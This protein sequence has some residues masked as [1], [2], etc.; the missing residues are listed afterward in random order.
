MKKTYYWVV[1]AILLLTLAVSGTL[2]AAADGNTRGGKCGTNASWVFHSDTGELIISGQGDMEDYSSSRPPPWISC[3]SSITSVKIGEGITSIANYA[4]LYCNNLASVSLPNSLTSVGDYAFYGCSSLIQIPIPKTVTHLGNNAFMGCV[5]LKV[6]IL[7]HGI[8]S[9]PTSLFSGC[10]QLMAVNVPSTVTDIG[11]EAFRDCAA[12]PS[13]VLPNGITTVGNAAF[14]G[15]ESLSEIRFPA[16]VTSIGDSALAFCT[17][18]KTVHLPNTLTDLGKNILNGSSPRLVLFEGQKEEWQTVRIGEENSILSRVLLIHP[19]HLFNREVVDPLYHSSDADCEHAATC[20]RSCACGAAGEEI[21]SYGEPLGHTGGTATCLRQ[22]VCDTCQKPYGLLIAHS[23]DGV[24]DC[25]RGVYCAVCETMLEPAKG[26][27]HH[28]VVV[29]PTCTEEGYTTHTCAD[30][31]DTY[32][33]T[34]IE[35]TGHTPGDAPTCLE[36]QFCTV[37]AAKLA[38]RLGHSYVGVVTRTPTCT[39]QGVRT[40]SCSRCADG[41]A[42]SIEPT[43]HTEGTAP[44]C[45]TP[46]LCTVCQTVLAD[47]LGHNYR[48]ETVAPTC[49]TR[50]HTAHTCDRCATTY[51]DEFIPAKGH[52]PGNAATCTTAQTCTVCQTVLADS[53]GHDYRAETVAP[54]CDEQGYIRH[55]CARCSAAY[56]DE[57]VPAKGH[58]PGD[59][60]TCTTAQTCTVCQTVLADSPGHDYRAETV[61]PTCVGQGYVRHSCARCSAAYLDELVPAKGHVPGDAPTC[62]APQTCTVCHALLAEPAEHTYEESVTEATCTVDGRVVHTCSLCGDV[63][64]DSIIPATGHTAGDWTVDNEPDIGEPGRQHKSC[65]VCSA[66]LEAETFWDSHG[67]GTAP[68]PDETDAANDLPPEPNEKKDRAGC[69]ITAG[70]VIVIVIILIAAFVLWYLDR[71]RK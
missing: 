40:H 60:P 26:H 9:I 55:S 24:A 8:T 37:C 32:T 71:R 51:L 52:T 44:T 68:T 33:D 27:R 42:E 61:D 21:F 66:I 20:Y 43:G 46:Q 25:V 1:A 4:F 11:N 35:A 10:I 17:G 47:E 2:S 64:I 29:P 56:L 70:N 3:C 45:L 30:C 22:A 41:Y 63:Y 39:E 67:D 62:R 36:D 7:P 58:V 31:S 48:A 34:P 13:M 6:A 5:N 65:G 69:R 54:T 16:G 23:P 14:H 15:C 19:G 59:A 53:S 50:G 49:D 12:L 38:D 57:L 28:A 18:L